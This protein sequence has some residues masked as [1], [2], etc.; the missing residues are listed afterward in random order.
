DTAN[1]TTQAIAGGVL[2]GDGTRATAT[3]TSASLAQTVTQDRISAGRNVNITA[4]SETVGTTEARGIAAGVLAI[5]VSRAVTTVTPN[6][7]ASIGRNNN[8]SAASLTLT[9]THN[10]DGAD[11]ASAKANADAYG[12]LGAGG[13]D[14]TAT[15]QNASVQSFIDT[16]TT[17]NVI[18]D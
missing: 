10:A 17:V 3:I 2:A 13:A 14:V 6:V 7:Q 1:G 11:S 8:L 5:G 9:A 4:N 16:G 12:G 15:V 18:G